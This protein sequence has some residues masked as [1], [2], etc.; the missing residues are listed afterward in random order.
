MKQV[1]LV[2]VAFPGAALV[3]VLVGSVLGSP[4]IVVPVL[5]A[6]LSVTVHYLAYRRG[7]A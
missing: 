1:V 7:R 6:L 5:V 2:T 4:T 3:L